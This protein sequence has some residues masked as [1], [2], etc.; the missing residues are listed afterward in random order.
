MLKIKIMLYIDLT[1]MESVSGIVYITFSKCSEAALAMEE[2][3]GKNIEGS[4]RPL[5]VLT[6]L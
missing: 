5:K 3:N 1:T 4:P 2:M 6:Y